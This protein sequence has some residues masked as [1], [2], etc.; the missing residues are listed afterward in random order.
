MEAE[1]DGAHDAVAE[2]LVDDCFHGHSIYLH[3]LVK[4]IDE[5]ISRNHRA[6][7]L[8]G[9]LGE[10]VR[11]IITHFQRSN[12]LLGFLI[13]CPCLSIEQG[14]YPNLVAPNYLAQLSEGEPPSTL[15]FE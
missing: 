8:A 7:A 1:V 10:S 4:A 15:C 14:C 11:D 2:F 12:E 9:K 5:R 13:I 6:D 3:D